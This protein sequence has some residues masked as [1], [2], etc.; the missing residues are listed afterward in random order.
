MKDFGDKSA[1]ASCGE[2]FLHSKQTILVEWFKKNIWNMR[3]QDA[4]MNITAEILLIRG[5]I[6]SFV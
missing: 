3:I 1:K 6:S 5:N 2:T 4:R